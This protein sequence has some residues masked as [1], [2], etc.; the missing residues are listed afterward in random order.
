MHR[1]KGKHRDGGK[2]CTP[3][4]AHHRH[5]RQRANCHDNA[6]AENRAA[7]TGRG[8]PPANKGHLKRL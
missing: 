3:G 5:L 7:E 1:F 6:L 8:G 2:V 4:C